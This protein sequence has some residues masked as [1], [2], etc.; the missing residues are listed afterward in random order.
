MGA[1]LL[2]GPCAGG[3]LD[4]QC[5]PPALRPLYRC[6]RPAASQHQ[7][8]GT[9]QH[10]RQH[11]SPGTGSG[12][13]PVPNPAAAAAPRH[14]CTPFTR[15]CSSSGAAAATATV[16]SGWRCLQQREQR[17]GGELLDSAAAGQHPAV[18]SAHSDAAVRQWRWRSAAHPASPCCCADGHSRHRQRAGGDGAICWQPGCSGAAL[19]RHD[20]AGSASVH[21]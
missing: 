21:Q 7:S 6:S 4:A 5:H 9:G 2:A 18:E 14:R 19:E 3:I 16:A 8:G 1:T 20:A 17:P 10:Q 15:P 13:P 11:S 12:C